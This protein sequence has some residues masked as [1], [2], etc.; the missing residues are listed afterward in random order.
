M[1]SEKEANERLAM[2]RGLV[3]QPMPADPNWNDPEPAHVEGSNLLVGNKYHAGRVDGLVQLG[4]TA[5]LNCASG[6]ISR[7]PMDELQDK[8]ILYH[9]TNVRRDDTSYPILFDHKNMEPSKHLQ[10][11]KMLYSQVCHAGGKVLFFCVAGQNR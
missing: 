8:G 4:V 5:M 9:F 7:L 1:L 2:M 6:G 11:A 3:A 10:I